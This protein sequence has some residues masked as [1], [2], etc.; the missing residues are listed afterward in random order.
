PSRSNRSSNRRFIW[1]CRS[2]SDPLLPVPATEPRRH[3][4][5]YPCA[6]LKLLLVP[7]RR[8]S[9][10][11]RCRGREGE[12]A[13]RS[14]ASRAAGTTIRAP[15]SALVGRV[16]AQLVQAWEH[17]FSGGGQAAEG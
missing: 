12:S 15:G 17:T 2:N 16:V 3:G 1:R 6:I 4:A 14:T 7:L 5:R 13:S 10:R 9:G 8:G 11:S